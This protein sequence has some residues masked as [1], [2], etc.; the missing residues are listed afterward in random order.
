MS[1]VASRRQVSPKLLYIATNENEEVYYALK[2]NVACPDASS[3]LRDF[4]CAHPFAHVTLSYGVRHCG[5]NDQQK[6]SSFWTAKH[7]CD[8]LLTPRVVCFMLVMH[9][10][11]SWKISEVCELYTL[12]LSL[13]ECIVETS[14]VLE[15]H[16]A[17]DPLHLSWISF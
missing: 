14:T 15:L 17:P 9:T 5:S 11:G 16:P 12:L 8:V 4:P 7:K 6:W 1:S 3:D 2:I 10:N 13:R